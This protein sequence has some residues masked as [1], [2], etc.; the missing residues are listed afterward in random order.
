[1]FDNVNFWI[2]KGDFSSGNHFDIIPYL[3]DVTEQHNEK[4][5]YKCFGYSGNINVSVFKT[6][7]SL[8]GS[9]AKSFFGDNLHTLTRHDTQQAVEQL[10]DLLHTDINEAKVTSF[11][12]STIILTKRP[13]QDYYSFLGNKPYFKRLHTAPE[14]LYYNNHQKQ[15]TFYDKTKEANDKKTQIPDI[16]QNSNLLRY[17]LRYIKRLNKQFRADITAAKLYDRDFYR[18]IIQNWHNEFKTIQKLKQQ[19]F[20]T[21]NVNSLKSAK[22]AFWA[23]LL[24]EKG[25]GIID[26]Y[27][28]VLKAENKLKSRSDYTRLKHDLSQILTAP[29]GAQNDLMKELETELFNIA[30]YAR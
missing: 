2:D 27:L 5:G 3:S 20:M 13:P 19:S 22:E 30:K 6:G 4:A 28:N 15:I 9:L 14:T 1:M 8:K 26:E 29:Q 24:Q 23:A 17:E 12:V 18:S 21:D 7:I 11:E 16:L 25:Q 10:S